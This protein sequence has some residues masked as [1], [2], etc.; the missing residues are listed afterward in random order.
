[1]TRVCRAL[2]SWHHGWRPSLPQ[3]RLHARRSSSQALEAVQSAVR[4]RAAKASTVEILAVDHPPATYSFADVDGTHDCCSDPGGWLSHADPVVGCHGAAASPDAAV[5][6]P[7]PPSELAV[8]EDLAAHSCHRAHG[9]HAVSE[10]D[11]PASRG[12]CCLAVDGLSSLLLRHP[13]P[14]VLQLLH[15]LRA[16]GRVAC[17]VAL[18]HTVREV[19]GWTRSADVA[20]T[21]VT[22]DVDGLGRRC[23]PGVG[24]GG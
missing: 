4:G 20:A 24:D 22:G 1:M 7:G 11:S 8:L 6:R 5:P 18:L 2:H 23:V 19:P 12:G 16:G 9:V 14:C 3:Q 21:A 15:Q 10:S 17:I 13:A